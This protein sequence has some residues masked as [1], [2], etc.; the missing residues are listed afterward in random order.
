M[1]I[2]CQSSEDQH[3]V[4]W[5]VQQ[6]LEKSRFRAKV[7]SESGPGPR[8]WKPCVKILCVRLRLRK[9]WC[10]QH[11]GPCQGNRKNTYGHRGAIL[12]EGADWVGWNDGLN[13]ILDRLKIDADVWTSNKEAAKRRGR[14]GAMVGINR[15]YL[16]R[17]R[18]RRVTYF[19][20][21]HSQFFNVMHW[22][23]GTDADFEDY[24]GKKA[25]RSRYEEGTPGIP[26]WMARDEARALVHAG[27]ED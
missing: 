10:G 9:P 26:C 11:A 6:A 22:V 23:E 13:D 25:P 20:D 7:T 19:A 3:R 4:H 16:R 21:C 5:A 15:F 2:V 18:R 1:W 27:H 14:D 12:L 24:C 8:G 17:G